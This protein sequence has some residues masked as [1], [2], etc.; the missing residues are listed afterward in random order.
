MADGDPVDIASIDTEK[1]NKLINII[2]LHSNND[3]RFEALQ[4]LHQEAERQLQDYIDIKESMEAMKE[5]GP[6]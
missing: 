1:L 2:A 3:S 4:N 6:I 5:K